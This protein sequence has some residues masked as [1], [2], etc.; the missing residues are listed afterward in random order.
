MAQATTLNIPSVAAS[1]GAVTLNPAASA[2]SSRI[3]RGVGPLYARKW[4]PSFRSIASWARTHDSQVRLSLRV[5]VVRRRPD[6]RL[7]RDSLEFGRWVG[8]LDRCASSD[9]HGDGTDRRWRRWRAGRDA[10]HS[11]RR[12]IAGCRDLRLA[13]RDLLR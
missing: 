7:R 8:R 4:G 2:L 12:H 13:W 11:E 9:G 6:G 5:D 3:F 10:R 1:R